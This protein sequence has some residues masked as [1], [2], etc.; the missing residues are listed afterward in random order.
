MENGKWEE[1]RAQM[2]L[3]RKSKVSSIAPDSF[4]NHVQLMVPEIEYGVA[5][6]TDQSWTPLKPCKIPNPEASTKPHPHGD[7]LFNF[8]I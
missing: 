3:Y 8:L 7:M 2:L 5:H 4:V 1:L 6:A